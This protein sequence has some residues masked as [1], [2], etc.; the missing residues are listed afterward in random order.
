MADIAVSSLAAVKPLLQSVTKPLQ[1]AEIVDVGE[2][3]YLNTSGK[4]ALADANAYLTGKVIGVI[5]AIGAYGKTSSVVDEMVDVVF[6]GPV[7]GWTGL[8]PGQEL[9]SSVVAGAIA[10]ASPA[11]ASGDFRYYVGWAFA[12]DVIF[13]APFTDE[14]A[15][16]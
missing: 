16:L 2:A 15:A 8:T 10:D 13:V 7:A 3:V 6:Y 11:G 9:F 4:V 1:C 14:I 5:G 12:A